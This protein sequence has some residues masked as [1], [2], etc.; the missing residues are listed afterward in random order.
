MHESR[1]GSGVP[2]FFHSFRVA[3][4]I[5]AKP[6]FPAGKPNPAF[7][8]KPIVAMAVSRSYRPISR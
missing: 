2:N 1:F 8:T 5:G 3:L 4:K 7:S 6:G